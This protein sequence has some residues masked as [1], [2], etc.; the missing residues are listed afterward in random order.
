MNPCR[1]SG[2]ASP[3]RAR[4]SPYCSGHRRTLERHGHPEQPAVR[5]TDLAPFLRLIER[6]LA[7]N[8]DSAAWRILRQRWAALVD[9]ANAVH[10]SVVGGKAYCRI[11]VSV[12][13]S[14]LVCP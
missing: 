14:H 2:C 7:D 12:Q 9:E 5:S 6:R 13:P 11:D 1:I 4:Y 10:A 8:R 3:V